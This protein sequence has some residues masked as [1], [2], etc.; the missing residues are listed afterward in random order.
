MNF[1]KGK[2][3]EE[4]EDAKEAFNA[5]RKTFAEAYNRSPFSKEPEAITDFL[6]KGVEDIFIKNKMQTEFG[7]TCA[8][9]KHFNKFKRKYYEKGGKATAD[10]MK[11]LHAIMEKDVGYMYANYHYHRVPDW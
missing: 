9:N 8:F 10:E 6:F 7:A 1:K 11:N 2:T 5:Y 4:I 3:E